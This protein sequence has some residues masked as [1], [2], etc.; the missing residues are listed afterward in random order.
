VEQGGHFG[1]YKTAPPQ[2]VKKTQGPRFKKEPPVGRVGHKKGGIHH[3]L[4][5]GHKK[6]RLSNKRTQRGGCSNR[7][8]YFYVEQ[9]KGGT[10][11]PPKRGEVQ[12]FM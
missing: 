9:K 5:G 12:Q 8:K 4:G 7:E 11:H 6:G 3:K 10:I 1:D 2:Y